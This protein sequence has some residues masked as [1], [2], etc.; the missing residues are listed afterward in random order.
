VN[1]S[2]IGSF[3]WAQDGTNAMN[4]FGELATVR[5]HA[6]DIARQLGGVFKSA[7]EIDG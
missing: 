5:E 2:E 7:D 4:V 6:V 1:G 3:S